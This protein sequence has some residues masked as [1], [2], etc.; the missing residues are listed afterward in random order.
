M[1]LEG[2][3]ELKRSKLV[4]KSYI[5]LNLIRDCLQTRRVNRLSSMY[6]ALMRLGRMT[7]GLLWMLRGDDMDDSIVKETMDDM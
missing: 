6:R 1:E 4:R 5:A 2:R 7:I 3:T